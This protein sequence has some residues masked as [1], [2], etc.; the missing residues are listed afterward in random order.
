M[1]RIEIDGTGIAY[2]IIGNGPRAAAITPGGRFSKDTPGIRELAR[3]LADSGFRVLIWDRPNCGESDVA[4]T[5][6]SESVQNA[7]TLAGLLRELGMAPALLFGG[8]GGARET[9][10]TAIRHPDVAG[11]VFVLWLSGG[12][13]GI[14]TLPIAYYADSVMSALVGGMAAVADLPTWKEVTERNPGNRDRF[15]AMDAEAFARKLRQWGDAF[16]PAPGVPIPCVT[17]EQL[18]RIELPVMILRSGASDPHHP[19]ETSEV[20]AAMIPGA[21]MAEPPWGDRE[22]MNQLAATGFGQKPGLFSH[23]PLLAPQILA[24]AGSAP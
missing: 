21:R 15:L 18:G 8:S 23:W 16:L 17:V 5:G 3:E 24:F 22:W 20:V 10:I 2:E 7:D 11:R 19:R 4:F 1:A 14:G 6:E 9:L 12:G 13:I